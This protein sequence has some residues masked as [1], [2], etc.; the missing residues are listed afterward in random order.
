MSWGPHGPDGTYFTSEMEDLPLVLGGP[1]R[2]T[3]Q[4]GAKEDFAGLA[5]HV[6]QMTGAI[7]ARRMGLS[8]NGGE[9]GEPTK[10]ALCLEIFSS[11]P[12]WSNCLPQ[13]KLSDDLVARLGLV[14]AITE[15]NDEQRFLLTQ[16]QE[17]QLADALGTVLTDELREV[18]GE[19]RCC[20]L[21][22]LCGDADL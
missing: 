10:T 8:M 22:E 6:R 19:V 18:R 16:E 13:V 11:S 20:E 1:L 5:N 17:R 12:I 21:E 14:P 15:D 9:M 3:S 2:W 7:A 4:L